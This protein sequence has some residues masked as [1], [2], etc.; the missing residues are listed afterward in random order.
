MTAETFLH[1]FWNHKS[2]GTN[3]SG[4]FYFHIPPLTTV[5]RK[6]HISFEN[7]FS[8]NRSPIIY[9]LPSTIRGVAQGRRNRF[10]SEEEGQAL[11]C[12]CLTIKAPI[13]IGGGVVA[14]LE[15]SPPSPMVPPLLELL[16]R[17]VR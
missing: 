2:S 8:N 12:S 7:R 4:S 5:I 1:T 16:P 3:F 15:I 9:F 6:K 13:S 14:P 10:I 17:S 11:I